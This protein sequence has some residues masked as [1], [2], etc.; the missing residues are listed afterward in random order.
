MYEDMRFHKYKIQ[1]F[2][3][4][5]MLLFYDCFPSIKQLHINMLHVRC[6]ASKDLVIKENKFAKISVFILCIPLP[7]D[8][9]M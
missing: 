9:R 4:L 8:S 7:K 3:Y 5:S 6:Y 2:K 1:I